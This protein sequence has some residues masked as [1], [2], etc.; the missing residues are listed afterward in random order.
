MKRTLW[1]IALFCTS[2]CVDTAQDQVVVPLSV[3]GTDSSGL[4]AAGNIP[5]TLD[6]ADLAFG[7]L[8]LCSGPTAGDL[9]DVARL[10]W[11]D[12]VVVDATDPAPTQAGELEGLSG[13]VLSWMYDLGISSQLTRTEP[14]VL[15]AAET[16]GGVSLVI[17]GQAEVDGTPVGFSASVAAQQTNDTEIG[18]PIVRRSLS[19]V[20]NRDVT[21]DEPGLLIRFDPQPWLAGVDFRALRDT[22]CGMGPCEV[23]IEDE[24]EAFRSIRNAL[25]S[26]T[27]PTFEWGVAP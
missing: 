3:A 11:L 26:G 21:P 14:F 17:S 6:R 8:Y 2:A 27:R 23:T 22:S 1:A 7:P 16:L 20:F 10:E 19:E 18:V 9:C 5:V 4:V 15:E 13:V 12:S 25:V 24:T